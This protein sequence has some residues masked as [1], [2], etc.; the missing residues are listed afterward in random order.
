MHFR[1]TM[2]TSYADQ[3]ARTHRVEQAKREHEWLVELAARRQA[4]AARAHI[5]IEGLR[6]KLGI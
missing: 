1:E 5:D 2:P 6:Q 4:V 3:L